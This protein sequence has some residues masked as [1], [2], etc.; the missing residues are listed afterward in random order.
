MNLP[1]SE[2]TWQHHLSNAIA[3]PKELLTLLEWD[4][5]S[6]PLDG[7]LMKPPFTLRVPRG[8]VERMRKN[9]AKDPLLIQVLPVHQETVSPHDYIADPLEEESK[10]HLPGL[11]HKYTHRVLLILSGACA[12]HCRYCF[13]REFDYRLNSPG[14][15]GWEKVFTYIREQPLINEVILSGGDPLTLGDRYLAKLVQKIDA[16]PHIKRL[17]IHTR[18]PVVLPERVTFGLLNA[19]QTRLKTVIVVHIN[20]PNEIDDSVAIAMQALKQQGI[21]LFNQS[22]LLKQVNDDVST[23]QALSEKLF[24][25]DVLPYYLHRLDKVKGTAHFAV[26]KARAIQI[27]R[28]LSAH[29][30]G[31]LVPKLVEEQAGEPSKTLII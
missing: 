10:N 21:T 27:M 8:F 24:A 6:M 11:L 30:P 12:V 4:T 26:D 17:R 22:V 31:Y 7:I 28:G 23:L 25:M 20:H 29:L 1:W 13:R 15:T 3:C 2:D 16:I 18:L 14:Q 9:D 19:L 5:Q